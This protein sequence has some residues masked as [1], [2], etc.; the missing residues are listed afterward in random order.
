MIDNRTWW[1]NRA[2]VRLLGAPDGSDLAPTPP[3][4]AA[5]AASPAG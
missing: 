1:R 4:G 5:P 3:D 2:S